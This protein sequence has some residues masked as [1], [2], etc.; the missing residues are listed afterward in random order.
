MSWFSSRIVAASWCGDDGGQEGVY[1]ICMDTESH[2]GG[3]QKFAAI[4]VLIGVIAFFIGAY[5]FLWESGGRELTPEQQAQIDK[6]QQ[7]RLE[8]LRGQLV[9][10]TENQRQVA[11]L[12]PE[13]RRLA[14][15]RPGDV[16]AQLLLAQF[17]Q[18]SGNFEAAYQAFMRALKIQPNQYGTELFAGSLAF[19]F[20]KDN[21]AAKEHYLAAAKLEPTNP[22]PMLYLANVDLAEQNLAAARKNIE[23]ALALNEEQAKAYAMLAYIDQK[24]D[25]GQEALVNMQRAIELQLE[26]AQHV[27]QGEKR[28]DPELIAYVQQYVAMQLAHKQPTQAMLALDKLSLTEKRQ[29]AV[30]RTTAEVWRALGR[31]REGG[32]YFRFLVAVDPANELAAE[33]AARCYL[34]AGDLSSARKMLAELAQINPWSKALKSLDEQLV[35][36]EREQSQNKKEN[37]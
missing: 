23:R 2:A 1:A 24:T 8:E 33:L 4:V 11:H 35:A 17:E 37:E 6:E 10:A 13:V 19:E 16:H 18:S 28:L 14:G 25:Q 34:D 20:L 31:P 30:M 27:G 12:L 32:D 9:L 5:V 36:A 21:A 15:N 22:E 29:P 7:A 3:K 26:H